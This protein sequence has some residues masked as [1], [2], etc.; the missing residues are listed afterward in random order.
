[1]YT[2]LPESPVKRIHKCLHCGD[3]TV[4]F[5]DPTHDRAYTAD[6]WEVIITDGQESLEKALALVRDDPKLFP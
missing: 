2:Q 4:R 5:Y 3:V 6:E 1:M